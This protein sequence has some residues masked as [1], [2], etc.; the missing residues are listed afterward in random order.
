[1]AGE[2]QYD[3]ASG[4]LLFHSG[5]DI[6]ASH[7]EG[8]VGALM[9]ECCCAVSACTTCGVAQNAAVVTVDPD[10]GDCSEVAGTYLY[11]LYDW[12]LG[13]I[14]SWLFQ[15]VLPPDPGTDWLW[16]DY[17]R[18]TDTWSAAING[19]YGAGWYEATN[20]DV[21]CNE[22]GHLSGVLLLPAADPACEGTA[23]LTLT[24]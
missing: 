3:A 8:V 14:C 2:L 21:T 13:E 20:L 24:T 5:V 10:D 15:K 7:A 16:V 4:A 12:D 19:T 23:T 6:C 22:D 9:A 1:M 11:D 17:N 18:A